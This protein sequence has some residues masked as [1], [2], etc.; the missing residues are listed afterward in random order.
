M[1]SGEH[2]AESLPSVEQTILEASE[3]ISGL[4]YAALDLSTAPQWHS[5]DGRTDFYAEPLGFEDGD[6]LTPDAD[7][8]YMMLGRIGHGIFETVLN[9]WKVTSLEKNTDELSDEFTVREYFVSQAGVIVRGLNGSSRMYSDDSQAEFLRNTFDAENE[10]TEPTLATNYDYALLQNAI[11]DLKKSV[12]EKQDEIENLPPEE[13]RRARTL[14]RTMLEGA[15]MDDEPGEPKW[16]KIVHFST[17]YFSIF[18]A[19]AEDA[20][21][22][23]EEYYDSRSKTLILEDF[24]YSVYTVESYSE[25]DQ[26][27]LTQL[28]EGRPFIR[29]IPFSELEYVSNLDEASE[30]QKE[31]YKHA[32]SIL[33]RG[34]VVG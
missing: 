10:R 4:K 7:I 23:L 3:I 29:H 12:E 14:K 32:E 5:N 25:A 22:D 15:R 1:T 30:A 18:A 31:A 24:G 2:F 21:L 13:L 34:G 20:V 6:P 11:F 9:T 8:P 19:S 28:Y 16:W 27:R 26:K 17:R 33:G